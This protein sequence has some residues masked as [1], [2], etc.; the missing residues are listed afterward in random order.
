MGIEVPHNLS[1]DTNNPLVF[2]DT[3]G[4]FYQEISKCIIHHGDSIFKQSQT[5]KQAM[6][7]PIVNV[8]NDTS[9]A[10]LAIQSVTHQ[11]E[12]AGPTQSNSKI[13]II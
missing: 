5:E 2:N 4:Q 8:I 12:V 6:W 13:K 10:I 11:G 1:I 7:P 3:I 9:S